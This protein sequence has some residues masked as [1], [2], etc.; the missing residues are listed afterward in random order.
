M[1]NQKFNVIILYLN[2][3]VSLKE[4]LYKKII[5]LYIEIIKIYYYNSMNWNIL[6]IEGKKIN[7]DFVSSGERKQKKLKLKII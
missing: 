5:Y 7:R 2:I 1:R 3:K 4:T 6:V